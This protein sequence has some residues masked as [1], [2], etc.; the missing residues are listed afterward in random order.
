MISVL[1]IFVIEMLCLFVWELSYTDF[2]T[3]DYSVPKFLWKQFGKILG[4]NVGIIIIA[5]FWV[6]V[7]ILLYIIDKKRNKSTREKTENDVG[8]KKN[9]II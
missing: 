5:N 4:K 2:Y 8:K 6:V 9:V 3:N 1:V 7:Y